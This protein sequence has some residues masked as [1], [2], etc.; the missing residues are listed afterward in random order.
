MIAVRVDNANDADVAPLTADFTFFGG[1]YR[2]VQLIVTD[3]R[4][5]QPGRRR[6]PGVYVRRTPSR[7]TRPR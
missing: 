1:L 6:G 2:G 5:R 7:P 3:G 4:V